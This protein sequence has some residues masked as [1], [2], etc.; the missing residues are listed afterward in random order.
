MSC[1]LDVVGPRE[2]A[3]RLTRLLVL[4]AQAEARQILGA[5]GS[6]RTV[7]RLRPRP[8]RCE[9][10]PML[11]RESGGRI[12]I[13]RQVQ[14]AGAEGVGQLDPGT[15]G[16]VERAHQIEAGPVGRV[17]RHLELR[18][19]GREAHLASGLVDGRA[20]ARAD[21]LAGLVEQGR[22]DRAVGLAGPHG[23]A[24]AQ[25][26]QVGEAGGRARELA[27]RAGVETGGDRGVARRAHPP[28]GRRVEDR[29][30][31]LEL[32][33]VDVERVSDAGDAGQAELFEVQLLAGVG[34]VP[35]D[36]RQQIGAPLPD[37][38]IGGADVELGDRRRSRPDFG[39]AKSPA[40]A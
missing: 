16:Q 26:L 15:G 2:T 23:L 5:N 4:A 32:Q 18:P 14:R 36:A 31:G 21:Q 24:R 40:G 8:L 9:L 20:H 12:R 34:G 10:G 35:A 25:G 29:L 22:R 1:E 38:R 11:T 3:R 33:A 7:G 19:H 28:D 30:R 39:R 13:E 37:A 27:G 6:Q 17:P